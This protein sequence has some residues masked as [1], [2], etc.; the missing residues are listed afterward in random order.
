LLTYLARYTEVGQKVTLTV[1]RDGKEMK[2]D[3]TL[4]ARPTQQ[5]RQAQQA[6]KSG[7]H[8]AWL[9]I[10]G[11]TLTPDIAKA[12]NL[13]EDQTG[14]LVVSVVQGSPADKAGLRGS[15]K[16]IRIQNQDVLIGG[17]IIVGYNGQPVETMQ[18]LL[19]FISQA[20]PGD[21][22]TLT[23]L[24]DGKEME[25]EVT[26]GERPENLPSGLTIPNR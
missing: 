18:D 19:A 4:G 5:R 23:V 1:L 25:V 3:V 10:V 22:V 20:S 17:D 24:R 16:P 6:E 11:L 12:M 13:P 2:V 26:L 7:P 9:G 8:R 21:K 14:V 15:Y